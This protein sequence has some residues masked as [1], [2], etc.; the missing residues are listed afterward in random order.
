[1]RLFRRTERTEPSIV[2]DD[3][4]VR[5]TLAD[6]SAEA[7]RWDDL[8]AVEVLTTSEGPWA[9]DVFFVLASRDRESGCVVPQA[10]TDDAF[11]ARL[12]ALDGFDNDALIEAMG[13]TSEATFHL[14]P[15][16]Q[17]V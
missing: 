6:G 9:E 13:S 7:I 14:W 4:G 11:L 5:R 15:P 16:P 10:E 2:I 17:R 12:Q 8:G 3:A 1:M